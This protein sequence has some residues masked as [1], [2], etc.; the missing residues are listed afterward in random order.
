MKQIYKIKDAVTNEDVDVEFD[1]QEEFERY[2]KG[3]QPVLKA[4]I[5]TGNRYQA[6]FLSH[7]QEEIKE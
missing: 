2:L 4:I 3:E 5:G 6:T 1:S 7:L